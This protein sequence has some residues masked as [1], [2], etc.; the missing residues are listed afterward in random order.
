MGLSRA[1][2]YTMRRM[3]RIRV[4]PHKLAIGFAAGVFAAFTPFIGFHFALGA[5]I[6]LVVR[7]NVIASAIGTFVGN[8]ITFPF[9]WIASYN[10]GA[11]M[12][13]MAARDRVEISMAEETHRFWSDGPIAAMQM[14]WHSIEPLLLPMLLGGV[15]LGL[16]FAV[17]SYFLVRA[18]IGQ[19]KVRRPLAKAPAE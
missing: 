1:W 14:L 16:A 12:L 6:A 15:P 7:G 3:A 4:S 2:R 18:S 19:F 13:G 11:L 5:L 17:G 9:M 10:L 8:P